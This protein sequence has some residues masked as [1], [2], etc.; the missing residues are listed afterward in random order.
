[1]KKAVS[2]YLFFLVCLCA[3]APSAVGAMQIVRDVPY[4]ESTGRFGLGDVFLP[5]EISSD[6]PVVLTIHGGGWS[7]GDR[8][9]WEGVS[10]FFAEGLGFVAYNI[11]YRLASPSNRWP[12]CG[13]DCVKAAKFL[14][15]SAFKK[16][17]ALSHDKIWI[18]GGSAGGHLSLW[19]LTS[20]SPGEV[21][22]CI[23]ISSIGDPAPDKV[24]HP[25]RYNTLFGKTHDL[26]AMDPRKGIRCGMAPVLCTHVEN[27]SVVPVKSHLA[28][29]DAYRAAGNVCRTYI[30]QDSVI[31]GLSGHCIWVPG[32]RPYRRL[33]PQLES[34]IAAFVQ[35]PYWVKSP[36]AKNKYEG[37]PYLC[38]GVPK[39]LEL[40]ETVKFDSVPQDTNRFSSVGACR[41]GELDGVKYLEAGRSRHPLHSAILDEAKGLSRRQAP[42]EAV[43]HRLFGTGGL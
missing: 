33:I 23:S 10:R 21:A 42:V 22:G 12:A 5:S 34:A 16:R 29:A 15:S 38:G 9:S 36:C 26:P 40:V 18:C 7:G 25:Y 37:A 8:A 35:N 20:L 31:K 24:L 2:R 1:M 41:I 3:C 28:F 13:N 39:G 27:D 11:E 19:T 6:T 30:Y 17:F 4:D 14:L 32:S 43:A